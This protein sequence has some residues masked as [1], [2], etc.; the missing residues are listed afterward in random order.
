MQARA[1]LCTT[2]KQFWDNRM[3]SKDSYFPLSSP[4][5]RLSGCDLRID[6]APPI[7][8]SRSCGPDRESKVSRI[9]CFVS[10]SAEH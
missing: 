7:R 10:N 3:D 6:R 9:T 2:S 8:S 5:C 1:M 4:Q